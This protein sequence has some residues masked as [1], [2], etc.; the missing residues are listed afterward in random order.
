MTWEGISN[1]LE[2]EA[3]V[4]PISRLAREREEVSHAPQHHSHPPTHPPTHPHTL[5][6]E[7]NDKTTVA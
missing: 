2:S 7:P 6:Q 5:V 4:L 1:V 3:P